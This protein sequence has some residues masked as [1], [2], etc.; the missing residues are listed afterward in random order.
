MLLLLNKIV[1]NN[2][3]TLIKESKIIRTGK[4]ASKVL[5]DFLSD[6]HLI[7]HNRIKLS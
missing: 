7:L 2:R 6:I 5:N 4:K 3:V 1:S